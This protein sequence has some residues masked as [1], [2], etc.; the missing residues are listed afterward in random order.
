MKCPK[1]GAEIPN[2]SKF[3]AFCGSSVEMPPT[4][5]E[6]PA[7]ELK[8]DQKEE[9]TKGMA[10]GPLKMPKNDPVE[11]EAKKRIP[12]IPPIMVNK[13]VDYEMSKLRSRTGSWSGILS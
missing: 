11:K 4:Q 13:G 9:S 10:D 12:H 7:E 5:T 6:P 3:C 2:D 1:C 8:G